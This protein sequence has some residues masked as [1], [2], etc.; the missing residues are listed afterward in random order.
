M[1]K[2]RKNTQRKR[3]GELGGYVAL[4]LV[5]T[6]AFIML[7]VSVSVAGRVVG[8]GTNVGY[9]ESFHAA[10]AV[11]LSCVSIAREKVIEGSLESSGAEIV[12]FL[13]SLERGSCEVTI[14]E[15]V[16]GFNLHVVGRAGGQLEVAVTLGTQIDTQT[17]QVT[18]MS[19]L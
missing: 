19:F 4:S 6:I 3:K 13:D 9:Y 18:S 12:W 10:R 5:S 11:A 1:I 8:V 17:G 7:I 14:T 2:A 16:V 15:T